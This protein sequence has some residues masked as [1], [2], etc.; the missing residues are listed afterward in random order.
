VP[1][2]LEV[3]D[4]AAARLAIGSASRVRGALKSPLLS[5][6]ILGGNIVAKP[7]FGWIQM[8]SE[9]DWDNWIKPQ[10]DRAV[11]L[12][13]NCV[14]VIGE[15]VTG[16]GLPGSQFAAWA[17]NTAYSDLTWGIRRT[18]TGLYRL[19]S[20][21]T[22][23]ATAPTGTGTGIVN[24]TATWD[25]A[26]PLYSEP[27]QADYL[28]RW[29]QLAQ[30]CTDVGISLYAAPVTR[31]IK[32]SFNLDYLDADVIAAV[33]ATAAT[34]AE[35]PCVIGLDVFQEGDQ[36]AWPWRQNQTYFGP[37]DA[38]AKVI[39]NGLQYIC[40]TQ[41]ISASS[42][43]GPS[44]TAAV[45]NDNTA[46]WSYERVPLL[47]SDV[48][49]YYAE[50]RD[51]I[52]S[53][54]PLTTSSV[55]FPG[56]N[57]FWNDFVGV[58]ADDTENLWGKLY[59]DPAGSDF[60]DIHLYN[61]SVSPDVIDYWV[62]KTGKPAVVGEFGVSQTMSSA[63]QTARFALARQ[64][65]QRQGVAGVV[66]WSLADQSAVTSGQYGVWDNTGYVPGSAPL[67]ITSGQRS[68]LTT[69]LKTFALAE[70]SPRY[71]PPELLPPLYA[72]PA[73]GHNGAS[74][75]PRSFYGNVPHW[76]LQANSTFA[77]N[78][79]GLG[80]SCTAGG[81]TTG[82]LWIRTANPALEVKPSTL[83]DFSA[84]VLAD[85]T[86]RRCEL[87]IEWFTDAKVSISTSTVIGGTDG[88]VVPLDLRLVAKSPSN[89]AYAEPKI[90][91]SSAQATNEV[92]VLQSASFK[93]A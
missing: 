12:G 36:I 93:E 51:E 7:G 28:A 56:V 83:Y 45:I 2:F 49:T 37:G 20:A 41:G 50:I 63:E 38:Q 71:Q 70:E 77:A 14:R 53:K 32:A 68:T 69:L 57:G 34:L 67:S 74:A 42:G 88:T 65:H 73:R 31:L 21:G 33:R 91:W 54:I 10:V 85:T 64:I 84:S 6:K 78:D 5:D 87:S 24:G 76:S 81:S 22:S 13:F 55:P 15:A 66:V 47:V 60:I 86:G 11:A 46:V 1:K 59:T 48:L 27:T 8:W 3:T 39:A 23:G 19:V 52:G 40:T 18:P 29:A 35:Y 9:W 80:V 61:N 44:G 25:Y 92:H 62:W 79:R 90:T 43:T 4:Q 17:P 16:L 75:R 72:R 89:A 82:V 30:Y 26:G 58:F